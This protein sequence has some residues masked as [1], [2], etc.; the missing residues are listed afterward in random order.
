MREPNI[1]HRDDRM[2][3]AALY[4]ARE[5]G[6]PIFPLTPCTKVPLIPRRR[7]GHGCLDATTDLKQIADWWTAWPTANIGLALG[8]PCGGIFALDIDPRNWGDR[9]L[10][11][12]KFGAL[13]DTVE[14]FSGGGGI[15]ILFRGPSANGLLMKGVDVKSTGGYIALP[16]SVHPN[17]K[18]YA[19]ELSSGPH[20]IQVANAPHDILRAICR[21]QRP[22]HGVRARLGH[23]V[24]PRSF[25]LGNAFLAAGWL[26]KQLRPGVW[27]VLCPNRDQHTTGQD[28]DT[29]T[30]IFAPAGPGGRGRFHCSHS[31]C[32]SLK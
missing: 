9:W 22:N 16:P 24:D 21:G 10:I 29:S 5:L 15:H 11:W 18:R 27:A 28:F 26:G 3:R 2:R 4:Y 7:K 20:Q 31:H 13:P 8:D 17:G 12:D 30:V 25:V 23:E 32:M 14:S 1:A 6:W 19:S